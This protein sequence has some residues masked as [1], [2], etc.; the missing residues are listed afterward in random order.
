MYKCIKQICPSNR[1]SLYY[2]IFLGYRMYHNYKYNE[3]AIL[4]YIEAIDKR[5]NLVMITEYLY[6]SLVLL[7]RLLNWSMAG[8]TSLLCDYVLFFIYLECV[9]II[10]K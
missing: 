5:F 6:E 3:S 4:D 2:G 10:H 8:T 1:L 9:C 7:R